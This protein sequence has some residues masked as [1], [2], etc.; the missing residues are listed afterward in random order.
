MT[1]TDRPHAHLTPDPAT[2]D[3]AS[4][5]EG[6][7]VTGTLPQHPG[8]IAWLR[9][10]AFLTQPEAIHVCDGSQE[11]ADR[12]ADQLVRAGTLVRLNPERRP[13]SYLARTDPGDVARVEQSTYI[14]SVDEGDAGPTN[15]WVD[16]DEMKQTLLPLFR[17]CMRGRILYVMPFC[18]GPLT[19]EAK[20][21]VE[22]T[23]SPYV[24]LSM[25][26]MTRMGAAV[27]TVLDTPRRDGSHPP[28]VDCLHSVGA[29][30]A[31]GQADVPW[32][33][34]PTKYIV[35]FPEER[36]IVSFGSGYGGNSL[37]GKKCFALRIAS[38]MARD[39][40]WLAEH[41]LVIRLTDREGRAHHAV[42][43]F[44]SACGKTNLAMLEP[45]LPGWR[46]E[47]LGDDIAWLRWDDQGRLRAVNPELG[48]FGVAP[49]TGESTNP[50]AMRTLA[51]GNTVF[52]NVALTDDGDVWWEGHSPAP[53]HAIDWLGADWT[54]R[55]AAKAAHPNSRFCTPLTQCPTLHPD[56]DDPAGVPI[57]LIIFGGRRG[58]TVPLVSEARDWAHGVFLGATLSSETTAAAAGQVGVLRRDP[59]AMLPFIGYHVGDYFA[60]WLAQDSPG[61]KLP[62]IF[63]VNWFRRN[64]DGFLWPGFSENS[65]VLAWMVARLQGTASAVE[66]PIGN[67]PTP[68]ALDLSGLDLPPH[69]VAE[70]LAVDPDEW[71]AEVPRVREWLAS[72]GER[73]PAELHRQVDELERRLG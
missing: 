25:R 62:R 32:P 68:E 35:H 47:T 70:A 37:L 36:S 9:E 55:S 26:V 50:V 43:A 46:V 14:C 2:P 67:V 30:L 12:L 17:G 6:L 71:R 73:V 23:D 44:P 11:E 65:R 33:C 57:D 54:P 29:P 40:G 39:E 72:L 5:L 18:M 21:G 66:T 16:P 28:F 56:W 63:H 58:S 64:D 1:L 60:H 13:H 49:G 4:T 20:F 61:R 27:Q 31:P 51:A 52:T 24:V 42:A 34:N 38:A 8:V 15:N 10:V 69:Q 3:P 48:F 22:I 45:T 53:E 19:P 7:P 59:M 41:M